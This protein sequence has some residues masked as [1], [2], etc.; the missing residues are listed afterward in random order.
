MR[1]FVLFLIIFLPISSFSQKE[2]FIDFE[3]IIPS[4]SVYKLSDCKEEYII[5]YFHNPECID[6]NILKEKMIKDKKINKLIDNK[7]LKVLCIL[8]DV[9]KNYWLFFS[10]K[11]P[12]NWTNGW[13]EDDILIIKTYLQVLPSLYLVKNKNLEIIGNDITLKKVKRLIK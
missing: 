5:I 11:I 4:D 9:D 8:P 2:K 3:Y 12:K 6:C 13:I 7:T 10:N 1:K